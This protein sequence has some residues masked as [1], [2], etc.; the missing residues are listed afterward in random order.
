MRI[1]A[2]D[3]QGQAEVVHAQVHPRHGGY[4]H[5]LRWI[6]LTAPERAALSQAILASGFVG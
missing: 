2:L 6:G 1:G 4:R 3:F 5:S